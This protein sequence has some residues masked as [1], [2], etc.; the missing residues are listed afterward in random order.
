[1]NSISA[2]LSTVDPA[3]QTL[4]RD[5]AAS[6]NRELDGLHAWIKGQV[7]IL[8]ENR[9]VLVTLHDSFQYFAQRY[10][11]RDSRIGIPRNH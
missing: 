3:G 9:R 5:N 7:E 10:G 11:F 1:M 6:Y 4:Y 2:R 8:P